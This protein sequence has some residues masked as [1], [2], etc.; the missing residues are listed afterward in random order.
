M[1]KARFAGTCPAFADAPA[2]WICTAAPVLGVRRPR[3]RAFCDTA[4]WHKTIVR[5]S[6]DVK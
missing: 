4:F 3:F 6:D 2:V 1:A 5:V